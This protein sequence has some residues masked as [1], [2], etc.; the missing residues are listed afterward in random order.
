MPKPTVYRSKVVLLGDPEVGKTSLVRRYLSHA[1]DQKY[2][3]T[4][5]TLISKRVEEFTAEGGSPLEMSLT[6]WDI[7]GHLGIMELLREAY[8]FDARGCLAVFDLT[9]RE[10]LESLREW[11]AAARRQ[12]AEI[13]IVVLGNKADLEDRR[14]VGD[15][16]AHEYCRAL[17]VP[18]MLTSA[19]TGLNVEGAFRELA[20]S[21]LRVQAPGLVVT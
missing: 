10:T 6:I 13:P 21:I 5:G 20:T 1:F 2:L 9:R 18:Y 19:K 7:M 12:G 3:R 14:Q 8:F 16:E 15:A 17:G 4:L 11:V